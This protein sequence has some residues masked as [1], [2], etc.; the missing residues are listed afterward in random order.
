MEG[1]K[2]VAKIINLNKFKKNQSRKLKK[3]QVEINRVKF[4]QTKVQKVHNEYKVHHKEKE[5]TGKKIDGGGT[6]LA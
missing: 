5:L 3:R 6:D 1:E 4:G 2:V